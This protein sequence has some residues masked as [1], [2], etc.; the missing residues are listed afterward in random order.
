[1]KELQFGH[2]ST[3]SA[4]AVGGELQRNKRPATPCSV[5]TENFSR[6]TELRRHLWNVCKRTKLVDIEAAGT[7]PRCQ[8]I[9]HPKQ[10]N[11][12]QDVVSWENILD[13]PRRQ[14]LAARERYLYLQK[15]VNAAMMSTPATCQQCSWERL[16]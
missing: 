16:Y 14:R 12:G 10:R 5:P 4:F 13:S 1:M 2:T 9:K 3:P 15:D 6:S 8:T 7:A 11:V